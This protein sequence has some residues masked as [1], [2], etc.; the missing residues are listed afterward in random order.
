MKGKKLLTVALAI[1]VVALSAGAILAATGSVSSNGSSSSS[2]YCPPSSPG[3]GQPKNPPPGN[4]CGTPGSPGNPNAPGKGRAA[5]TAASVKASERKLPKGA[6]AQC[7]ALNR[8]R[9]KKSH[10]LT[11]TKADRGYASRLKASL[12]KHGY[13]CGRRH[14]KDVLK[15]KSRRS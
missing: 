3:G 13:T 10:G 14:G 1:G 9:A 4:Q 6:K 5:V 15:R 12:K 11:L 2:Q 8:L 7:H